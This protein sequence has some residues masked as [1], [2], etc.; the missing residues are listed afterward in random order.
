MTK[1]QQEW[2][3][4][5]AHNLIVEMLEM[6]DRAMLTESEEYWRERAQD[7]ISYTDRHYKIEEI[8]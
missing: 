8:L 6:T 2:T 5:I 7:W 1:E 3:Y 4:T